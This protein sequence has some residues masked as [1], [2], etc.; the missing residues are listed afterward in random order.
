MASLNGRPDGLKD[1]LRA[2]Q[3]AFVEASFQQLNARVTS[4]RHNGKLQPQCFAG[5]DLT[6]QIGIEQQ[7][8]IAEQVGKSVRF[9]PSPPRRNLSERRQQFGGRGPG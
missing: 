2:V 3:F 9:V 5:D 4:L 8:D 7:V 1:S 6:D